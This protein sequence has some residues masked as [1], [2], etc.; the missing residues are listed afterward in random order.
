MWC[1]FATVY[2]WRLSVKAWA[3]YLKLLIKIITKKLRLY[4]FVVVTS[5]NMKTAVTALLS[6]DNNLQYRFPISKNNEL[7][8]ILQIN[9]Y[10]S[11]QNNVS[12]RWHYTNTVVSKILTKKHETVVGIYLYALPRQNRY[13]AHVGYNISYR[14]GFCSRRHRHR[15]CVC[16][17][18]THIHTHKHIQCTCKRVSFW[19]NT[20]A[21]TSSLSVQT[22]QETNY[23]LLQVVVGRLVVG[24]MNGWSGAMCCRIDAEDNNVVHE[25]R[26][27]VVQPG[28]KGRR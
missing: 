26:G 7:L 27:D 16:A 5:S 6:Y 3:V 9:S 15:H 13:R 14:I 28:F 22:D 17:T 21:C 20:R 19:I 4:A 8:H 18:H 11:Q 23:V 25:S 1:R 2:R 24:V 10:F 12:Y